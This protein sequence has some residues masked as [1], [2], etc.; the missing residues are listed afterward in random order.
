MPKWNYKKDID[1]DNIDASKVKDNEF[2]FF[3]VSISSFI[4]ITSE[5]YAN[6]LIEFYKDNKEAIDWLEKD[7]EIE[8]VQHGKSLK[9]YIEIVW[10][11]FDWHKAYKRFLELYL[12]LCNLEALQPTHGLEMVARMIVETGTSTFYRA[13]EKY[14]N[15]LNEPVLAKIAHYIYK[16][17]VNHYGYFD[18]YYKYYNEKERVGRKD[19]LKVII[20]RLKDVNSEDVELAYQAVYETLHDKEFDPKSYDLFHKDINKMASKHYPYSMAVKMMIHPLRMNNIV[21]TSM[22]PVI[23]TAM[24]V[25]GI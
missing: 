8:E 21:E 15:V 20:G 24:K 23:R 17:E 13:L 11:E 25:I 5:T 2:L 1:Y 18:K 9:R 14:S 22:V 3:I 12:P 6:N 4:E 16:D 7:W 19:V 10:P